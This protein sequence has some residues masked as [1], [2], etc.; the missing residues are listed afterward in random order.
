MDMD[1]RKGL[2]SLNLEIQTHIC[3]HLW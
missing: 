2:V 3:V 1:M